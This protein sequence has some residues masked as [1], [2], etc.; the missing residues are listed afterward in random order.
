MVAR[1]TALVF[2]WV[3]G[4]AAATAQQKWFDVATPDTSVFLDFL[5]IPDSITVVGA[6]RWSFDAPTGRLRLFTEPPAAVMVLYRRLPVAIPEPVN[7]TRGERLPQNGRMVVSHTPPSGEPASRLTR[8]GSFTRGIRVGTDRDLTLDS[9]MRF[10]LSGY[11]TDEVFLT[12]SL[13]DRSTPIHPDG[14]TQTLR[15][16]D[17]VRIRFEHPDWSVDMGDVDVSLGQG[18]F[19]RFNRRLQGVAGSSRLGEGRVGAVAAVMRGRFRTVSIRPL[20][21]VLGPYRLTNQQDEPFVVVVAG[22][23]TVYLDGLRLDRGEDQD[24]VIDYALGE[25]TFTGRRMIRSTHRLVVEYQ[26]LGSGYA[27]TVMA[28]E[29]VSGDVAGGRLKLGFGLVREADDIGFTENVGI[30]ED[31]RRILRAAGDDPRLAI[32]SGVD[33]VGFRRDTDRILYARRDT[34][35]TLIYEHR[36]GDPSSVFQVTFT[37]TEPGQGSYRRRAGLVNGSVYEW[38]GP[39]LGDFEPSRWL[40]MPQEQTLLTGTA[41]LRLSSTTVWKTD[42]L[43]SVFDRNRFSAIDQ[44]DDIGHGWQSSI[45]RTGRVRGSVLTR[46][47]DRRA[48]LFDRIDS[49]DDDRSWSMAV[50]LEDAGEWRHL[51]ELET[52]LGQA[53]TVSGTA[54]WLRRGRYQSRRFGVGIRSD[55]PDLPAI[56]ANA[57]WADSKSGHMGRTDGQVEFGARIRP[58]IRWEGEMADRQEATRFGDVSPGITADLSRTAT[59]SVFLSLRSDER[60]QEG[61]YRREAATTTWYSELE[62]GD[63]RIYRTRSRF[64]I[65]QRRLTDG[66]TSD[67]VAIRTD[68][69]LRTANRA[70]DLRWNYD[71]ATESRS[72]LEEVYLEVGPELGQ[73]VW[74]DVNRDGVRQIDEFFPETLPDEGTYIRQFRPTE[75]VFPVVN[76]SSTVRLTVDLMRWIPGVVYRGL[77]DVR[78]QSRTSDPFEVVWLNPGALLDV[79]N[80]VNGR[81]RLRQDLDLLRN[82]RSWDVRVHA[83]QARSMSRPVLG[84]ESG[85]DA[86]FG[87]S[88]TIRDD[89]LRQLGADGESAYRRVTNPAVPGRSLRIDGYRLSPFVRFRAAETVT[90]EVRAT[91]TDRRDRASQPGS[92]ARS[93]RI[94][95]DINGRFA[96]RWDA[97]TA[98]ELRE[99]RLTGT[100]S[101]YA[102]LELSEGAGPGRTFQWNSQIQYRLGD[103][104]RASLRYDGRTRQTGRPIQTVQMTVMAVF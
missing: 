88:V 74:I 85:K 84:L 69:E 78:E 61:T 68:T 93:G 36:P 18:A 73:Y 55:E 92:R 30:G 48:R 65:S 40:P 59:V 34:A 71:A 49:P 21:G 76:V 72:L 4:S 70:V 31:E 23:E 87:G 95:A 24:Y 67:G 8:S 2:C 44:N 56:A 60:R 9:G 29:A 27:R 7:R 3:L 11:V 57:S 102:E 5:V 103:G 6:V 98:V 10:D 45:E 22:T 94:R 54:G 101:P 53:S 91:L 77:L 83:D 90:A 35:G 100:P 37:R 28:A 99:V 1:L 33:S 58:A 17:Q 66:Q 13:T 14:T 47:I 64:T 75:S 96:Q 26:V 97:Q 20:E 51:L 82:H 15:E 80:T 42:A 89:G 62:A 41:A 46:R 16:F 43:L 38:V 81:I 19:L 39:G 79:S 25:I 50:P 52:D 86:R 32:A 104:I 63:G 12:A